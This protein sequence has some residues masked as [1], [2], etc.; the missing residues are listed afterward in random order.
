MR[1]KLQNFIILLNILL[2]NTKIFR[3]MKKGKYEYEYTRFEK[4]GQI[5]YKNIWVDKKGRIQ[6]RI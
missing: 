4:K 1:T 5:K 3:L 6:I 2:T